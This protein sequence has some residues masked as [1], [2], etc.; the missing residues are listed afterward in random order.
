MKFKILSMLVT[1]GVLSIMP[2]IYMGKV[3]PLSWIDLD[4]G[5]DDLAKLK[6][7]A[8]K[9]LSSAVTDEK[10]K[11]FKWRDKNG[12]MQFSNVPPP[13]DIDGDS[14]VEQL[15]L[16]PNSNVMKAVEVP[17]KEE[18]KEVAQTESTSP[19][20]MKGMKKVMQDT[21]GVEALLQKRHEAQ[22]EM[23]NNH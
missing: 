3:D 1:L 19:Y 13:V 8:P 17:I 15:E 7:K 2:M 4:S 20:S 10:V 6:A 14:N 11:V 21:K 18:P 5:A 12:V 22:Q 9:N 16:N 23:L